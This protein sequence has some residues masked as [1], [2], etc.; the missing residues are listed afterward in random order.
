MNDEESDVELIQ[1]YEPQVGCCDV[2]K[3]N[4]CK[5]WTVATGDMI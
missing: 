5:I 3:I 4:F 1:G 2:G